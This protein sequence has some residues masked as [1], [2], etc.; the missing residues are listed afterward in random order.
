MDSP[1]S[2]SAG[3]RKKKSLATRISSQF[4]R[5]KRSSSADATNSARIV[6]HENDGFSPHFRPRRTFYNVIPPRN[7]LTA[8]GSM[9]SA[10]R[11]FVHPPVSAA[12]TPSWMEKEIPASAQPHYVHRPL[13][14]EL[15]D[16]VAINGNVCLCESNEI[17]GKF[18]LREKKKKNDDVSFFFVFCCLF[19][20]TIEFKVQKF[21]KLPSNGIWTASWSWSKTLSNYFHRPLM[22]L[23]RIEH[24]SHRSINDDL[25]WILQE[26]VVGDA[27]WNGKVPNPR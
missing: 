3:N 22:M 27:V 4:E 16:T 17:N 12:V 20:Q 13:Y 15:D 25:Y 19:F 2:K 23:A 14:A 1:L 11:L 5:F 21:A 9:R 24:A 26:R 6:N 7:A 18:E 8:G 10:R